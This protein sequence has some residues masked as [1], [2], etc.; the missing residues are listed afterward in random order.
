MTSPKSKMTVRPGS[1]IGAR[2]TR[3]RYRAPTQHFGAASVVVG[4]NDSM[5]MQ[6]KSHRAELTREA[7]QGRLA[8]R[9]R[10][11]QKRRA[12]TPS[13]PSRP[14]GWLTTAIAWLRPTAGGRWQ[15]Q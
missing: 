14:G 11:K 2:V 10:P 15:A 9:V 13:P 8:A 4:M 3:I 6:A 7:G 12:R 1:E 5:L